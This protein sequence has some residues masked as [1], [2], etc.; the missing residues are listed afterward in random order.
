MIIVHISLININAQEPLNNNRLASDT[1]IRLSSFIPDSIP[2]G[3]DTTQHKTKSQPSLKAQVDYSSNDSISI[4]LGQ[5]KLYLYNNAAIEYQDI[6]LNANYVEFDLATS[7]S[8]ASGMIDSAGKVTGK[9]KFNKGQSEFDFD[10]MHYN[11]KTQKAII[12]DI[13][14]KQGDGY[15]HSTTTKRLADG[16]I[17]IQKGKY[18]TCDAEHP[19]FYIRLTKAISIPDEKI[20]SGP[21][22]LVIED[23]PLPLALPFGFLPNTINRASGFIFPTYGEEIY[24]G[25]YLRNGGWYFALNDYIDMTLLGSIYSRG[26]WGITG[27]STYRVKYKYSG[28]LNFEFVKNRIND[29]PDF[30]ATKDF[31]ISWNHSQDPK[32]NPTRKFSA[33]VNF[34]TS[35]YEKNQS[36]NLNDYLTNTKTS[37]ISY[38]KTWPG[39]P[40][41]LTAK[42][43][44]SQNDI[45]HTFNLTLPSMTF[46]IDRLY[47]F[48]GKNDDGKYNWFE[49]IQISYSAKLDNLITST[50]STFFTK[51]T[52]ESMRNGFYHSIPISLTGIKLFKYINI[53][54]SVS[55][56]GVLYTSYLEKSTASDASLFLDNSIITD[57]INKITYAH[58]I[59]TSLGISASP[60]L[61]G[62]YVSDKPDAYIAAVRHVLTPGASINFTP[63]MSKIMPDYYRTLVYPYSI[64]KPVQYKEYSIYE[65]YIYGTPTL[66][67]RS[68][69]ISLSLNNNLE[70]KL[71]P[72]NDTTS[73]L[74]KV[75]L[76]DNLNFSASYN[77]FATSYHWS[78]MNM[79]GSTS[80]FNKKLNLQFGATFDPYALDSTGSKRIDKYLINGNGKLF[81]VTNASVTMSFNLQSA[82]G[83]K[84][85]SQV[86]ATS[87]EELSDQNNPTLSLLDQST[88]Y[89]SGDY[90]DFDIP[91]SINVDYAWSYSK[92]ASKASFNHTVRIN[93]DI[94][95]TPKWKIGMNTGYDFVARKF[96][97][98]NINFHRDLHCWE[99][100]FSVVPFGDRRS[101]SFTI[102]AKQ[103]I[104][105]DLKYN[106]TKSW[107]DNF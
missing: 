76:L 15:L 63:D 54:P 41:N 70:M 31:R 61:Y 13:I 75:S 84:K 27:T 28:T 56:N 44:H 43:G 51:R 60:K 53:T 102:S 79:H 11:F 32:A 12:K 104:L 86:A 20:V 25:F 3:T 74:K 45:N 1:N 99:M 48:R 10:T 34:S 59:T 105:R 19:H 78:T 55:Y 65:N 23:M 106:K 9:P 46:N 24:R 58:S 2:S 96:T 57:T 22:Y 81:R 64:T 94:N 98:T 7:T 73:Q 47:P 82:A 103:S 92:P 42:L 5:Q 100:R 77:P 83:E 95:L 89:Y 62:M 52:L 50:D 90:V 38:S 72:R 40:F 35:S 107:Y 29:D 17:H 36:Y 71:R 68:G 85:K 49:K 26:T 16:E 8:F 14:T 67:G 91:W 69:S 18:T 39:S 101:Y 66:N 88:N 37:S 97:V 33:N 6:K 4:S 93:G 80:L 21:A 30:N 87:P